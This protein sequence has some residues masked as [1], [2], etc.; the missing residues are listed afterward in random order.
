MSS[1]VLFGSAFFKVYYSDLQDSKGLFWLVWVFW[2]STTKI[3]RIQK[4]CSDWFYTFTLQPL[5]NFSGAKAEDRQWKSKHTVG[6]FHSI[7]TENVK[8][9]EK[10]CCISNFYR[11]S[12]PSICIFVKKTPPPSHFPPQPHYLTSK[13]FIYFSTKFLLIIHQN[14][15]PSPTTLFSF[16]AKLSRRCHQILFVH[17]FCK[18]TRAFPEG[19]VL[20]W[21]L[22]SSMNFWICCK[23]RK[24]IHF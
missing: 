10:R 23:L 8:Y 20:V 11:G 7:L 17:F 14:Y 21:G 12:K 15:F 19:L 3:F 6:H 2:Y 16:T 4:G 1:V 13:N 9:P 22:P 18:M 24:P 5:W